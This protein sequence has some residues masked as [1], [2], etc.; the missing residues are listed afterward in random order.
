MY[1]QRPLIGLPQGSRMGSRVRCL[2]LCALGGRRRLLFPSVQ[3]VFR[4]HE[5]TRIVRVVHMWT[6]GCN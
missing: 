1:V 2:R 3:Y 5:E 4:A 6:N